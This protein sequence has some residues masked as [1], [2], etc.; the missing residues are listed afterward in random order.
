MSLSLSESQT[1]KEIAKEVSNFLPA[2]PHPFANQKISFEGIAYDL[3][4]QNFWMRGSKLISVVTF[5]ENILDKRRDIFCNVI[6][7]IVKR[8]I[9]YRENKKDPIT[10]QEIVKLN[11]LILKINFKIP[12]LWDEKFLASFPSIIEQEKGE[13]INAKSNITK[14]QRKKFVDELVHI[15]NLSPQER[16]YTFERFLNE[17][18]KV[19]N[20]NPKSPFKIKGEQIDGSLILDGEVYLIEAK[21]ESKQV[22]I[23][24]LFSFYEKIERKATWSRGIF[25]SYTG[26]TREAIEA[27]SKGKPTNFIVLTGQDLYF[28]LK[29]EDEISIDLDDAI[30]TKV[31]YAAETGSIDE[32]VYNLIK[33]TNK[34][35][36]I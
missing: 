34:R 21:W 17:I 26:F 12:E 2:R 10:R 23:K 32:T 8:G 27:F 18:F 20:L 33:K 19:F 35:S 30:R 15:S 6:V 24:E 31:R 11:N 36:K 14:E 13:N 4:L 7:E 1:I 25:I 29:G 22:G 9:T 5:L 28:I 16:G 3:G